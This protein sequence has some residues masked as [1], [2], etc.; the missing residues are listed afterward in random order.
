MI[1]KGI[2]MANKNRRIPNIITYLPVSTSDLLIG[3]LALFYSS[4]LLNLGIGLVPNEAMPYADQIINWYLPHYSSMLV[5]Y[6]FA[7]IVVSGVIDYILTPKISCKEDISEKLYVERKYVNTK[8]RKDKINEL[9]LEISDEYTEKTHTMK[10]EA[11]IANKTLEDIIYKIEGVKVKTSDKIKN[12]YLTKYI[13]PHALGGCNIISNDIDIYKKLPYISFSIIAHELAHRKRYFK[14]N[15]AEVLAHLAGF[16]TKDPVF[17]Q[18]SKV[19]RLRRECQTLFEKYEN[20]SK[21]LRKQVDKEYEDFLNDLK[22]PQKIKDFV[23]ENEFKRHSII[24]ECMKKGQ[25]AMYRLI[26][27]LF[28]QKEGPSRY[29][30]I[31]TEDLYALETRYHSIEELIKTLDYLSR[32]K[33]RLVS[34]IVK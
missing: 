18:S 19:S 5:N 10:E 13:M 20:V 28:G 30:R 33:T 22:L 12:S 24:V 14:E 27:K 6:T 4:R 34:C 17:I 29:T 25:I 9:C 2:T 26:M 1:L 23:I 16:A 3:G 32:F 7:G 15:D 21:E 11:E 8:K 31:F